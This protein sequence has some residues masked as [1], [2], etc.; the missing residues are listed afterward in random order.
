M[1]AGFP[2]FKVNHDGSL[3]KNLK[4]LNLNLIHS[5]KDFFTY[6][7]DKFDYIIS[8]RTTI[9]GLIACPISDMNIIFIRFIVNLTINL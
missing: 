7:P 5:N 3:I 9:R 4:D 1:T 2:N 6:Q 8:D